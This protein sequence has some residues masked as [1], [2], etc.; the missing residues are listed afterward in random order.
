MTI[1]LKLKTIFLINK[2]SGPEV[3]FL[4]FE[5]GDM[6]YEILESGTRSLG[7]DNGQ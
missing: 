2:I 1:F 3:Y 4:R 6:R 5:T 7:R